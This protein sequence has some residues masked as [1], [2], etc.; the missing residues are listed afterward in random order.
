MGGLS[1]SLSGEVRQG[2]FQL[3]F[4]GVRL[5]IEL[6]DIRLI[7]L[8]LYLL[9]SQFLEITLVDFGV[10]R[11]LTQVGAERV[12]SSVRTFS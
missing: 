1:L 2:L 8:D 5:P 7:L 12:W 4:L 11:D 10:G 3:L 6:L 9:I